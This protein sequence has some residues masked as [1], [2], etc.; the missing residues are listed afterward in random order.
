LKIVPLSFE[1]LVAVLHVLGRRL[2]DPDVQTFRENVER[3]DRDRDPIIL[4][5]LED[6]VPEDAV[7]ADQ[8][9]EVV[10]EV[11]PLAS[12]LA[13]CCARVHGV[14]AGPES[15]TSSELVYNI[16]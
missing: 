12:V 14:L 2:D 7:L 5:S 3:I 16:L 4:D 9:L 8:R 10:A 13:S 1:L 15:F 6:D 11:P